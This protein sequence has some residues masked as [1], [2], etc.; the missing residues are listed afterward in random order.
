MTYVQIARHCLGSLDVPA[1]CTFIT[2]AE[3]NDQNSSAL[4]EID[5][6][7]WA[8]ID[9][10]FANTIEKLHIA[11]KTSLQTYNA[12]SN[13][14]SGSP[15]FQAFKPIPENDSLANFHSQTLDYRKNCKLQFTTPAWR[16][17]N[18]RFRNVT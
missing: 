3:K 7:T 13:T 5:A 2:T 8:L 6:V 4:N 9:T 17:S 11:E 15:V 1:L 12:L 18:D 16:R 14:R 10:Q